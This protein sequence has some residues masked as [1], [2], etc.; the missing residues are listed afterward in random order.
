MA[1]AILGADFIQP[2]AIE[3]HEVV[4]APSWTV[5]SVVQERGVGGGLRMDGRGTM[6]QLLQLQGQDQRAGIIVRAV[7]FGEIWHGKAGVLK[8]PGGIAYPQKM[9]EL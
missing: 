1:L 6:S 2:A 5:E 8:N 3:T 9:I 4:E 7:S